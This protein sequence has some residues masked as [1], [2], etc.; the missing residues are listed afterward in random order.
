[1]SSEDDPYEGEPKEKRVQR[2]CDMCRRKKR[3][4]TIFSQSRTSLLKNQSL[5]AME[6]KDAINAPNTTS[7][8]PTLNHRPGRLG[9]I[10][11]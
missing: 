10:H 2:A 4:C 5:Q 7:Y 8:A 3:R 9:H 11:P 1:M 6:E